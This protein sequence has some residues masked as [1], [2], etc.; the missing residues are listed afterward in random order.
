MRISVVIAVYNG[1]KYIKQQIKSIF[2]QTKRV[3]E[4][5]LIDDCS[6]EN[7]SEYINMISMNSLGIR[8]KYIINEYNLGYAKTF[9]K[10][11]KEAE[12]DYIFFSDQ[13]DIWEKNKVEV[14]IDIMANNSKILCLSSL[15]TIINSNEEYVKKESKKGKNKLQF[16]TASMLLQ[17]KYLRPGMSLLIS[18]QLK[19]IILKHNLSEIKQ[20]DRF[21]EFVATEYDGFYILN[22]YLTRYRIHE[23]N[24]SGMNLTLSLRSDLKGRKIQIDKEIQYLEALKGT[25]ILSKD[26]MYL[27]EKL[28]SFYQKRKRMMDNK[29]FLYCFWGITHLKSYSSFKVLVGDILAKLEGR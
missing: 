29:L 24:T 20:H 5:I 27:I 1:K 23:N 4:I 26:N 10:A 2:S 28:I 16:V 3:N 12:G 9:F 21:I 15:N 13:D 18:K 22:E 11:L 19:K 8:I 14:M 25:C 6:N 17:Q 7:I